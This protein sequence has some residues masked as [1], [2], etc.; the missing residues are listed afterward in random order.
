MNAFLV[1]GRYGT[2][3]H[4]DNAGLIDW[5]EST[6]IFTGN[7]LAEKN[8]T[9]KTGTVNDFISDLK[10]VLVYGDYIKS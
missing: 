10:K 8:Y 1:I 2:N 4:D 3:Y 6:D 7:G 5:I 9:Q